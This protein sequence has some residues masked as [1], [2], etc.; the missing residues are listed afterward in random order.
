MTRDD[1]ARIQ[2]A[3]GKQHGGGVDKGSFASRT[4]R[5]A[6]KNEAAEKDEDKPDNKETYN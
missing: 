4:Q 1:A 6:D 3:E 2:R 5:A